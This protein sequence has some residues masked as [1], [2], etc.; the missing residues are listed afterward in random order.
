MID[1]HLYICFVVY[2][3]KKKSK[4]AASPS[5]WAGALGEEGFHKKTAN[6]LPRVPRTSTWGR[7]FLKKNHKFLPR[8]QHLGKSFFF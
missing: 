4:E 7:G 5:A 1:V 8:V 2:T 3:E 6:F